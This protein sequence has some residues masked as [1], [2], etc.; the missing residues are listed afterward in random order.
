M[1]ERNATQS[2]KE[3]V[4]KPP[5]LL[6]LDVLRGLIIILMA[7][8]HANYFI[9]QKHSPGEY[10][11]GGFPVYYD[12][13]AFLTRFV[14]HLCPPGFFFLMGAGMILFAV[15]RQKS[16]WS[17]WDITQHFLIRGGLLIALQFLIVNRAWEMSPG[18]WTVDIYFGVLSALGGT[19]ILGGLLLWLKP[20]YLLGLT[21]VL[22]IGAEL[23]VPD[24]SLWGP[25]DNLF[26]LVMLVSGGLGGGKGIEFWSNYPV[27]AWLELVTFGMVFGYWITDNPKKA[28]KR[29]FQLGVALLAG[30]VII[31]H[32]DGFGNIRP[33]AG[34]DWMDFFNPVKYPP[35]IGFSLLT[36]G[37]NLIILALLGLASEKAQKFFQPLAAF[38]RVPLFFYVIHLFLY[39]WLGRWMTPHGTSI[40]SMYPYWILGILILFPLC[41]WYGNFK[42]SLPDN[43]ILRFL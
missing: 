35:S 23:L 41:L 17:R 13:L 15:S 27:L 25:T 43:S 2:D 32:F 24:P 7:L 6:P 8:D 16:G 37:I 39:A 38:G 30:F 5:R 22:L 4:A 42:H 12:A 28:F 33:R 29:A 1:A 14:T 19:M 31:R 40:P 34:N 36:M 9:A 10:W 11:G 18:E 3:I 20:K 26:R 21:A